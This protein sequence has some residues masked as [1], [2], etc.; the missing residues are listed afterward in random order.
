LHHG[1]DSR[2]HL[3][4]VILPGHIHRIGYKAGYV[5]H[6]PME[7]QGHVID[8]LV[9]VAVNVKGEAL[10]VEREGVPAPLPFEPLRYREVLSVEDLG[11]GHSCSL[12]A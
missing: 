8:G 12:V 3:A 5:D 7:S 6:T 2:L 4:G 11:T 9:P 10:L 1:H